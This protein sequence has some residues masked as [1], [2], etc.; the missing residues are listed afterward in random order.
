MLTRHGKILVANPD[1][2]SAPDKFDWGDA[3]CDASIVGGMS[4]FS[5][6]TAMVSSGATDSIILRTCFVA[7]GVAFLGFLALKRGLIT[8]KGE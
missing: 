2:P 7:F 8:K 5:T 1:A 3:I 6:Y 4:A